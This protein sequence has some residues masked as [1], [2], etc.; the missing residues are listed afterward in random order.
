[1]R[2]QNTEKVESRDDMNEKNKQC[3]IK[4]KSD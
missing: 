1:M 4:N 3:K 2:I